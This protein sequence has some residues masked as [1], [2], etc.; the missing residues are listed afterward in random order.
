MPQVG[1]RGR[2]VSASFL[3]HPAAFPQVHVTSS[4]KGMGIAELRAAVVA[5][6]QT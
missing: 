3:G 2:Q 1:T 4:E 5:D 6:S